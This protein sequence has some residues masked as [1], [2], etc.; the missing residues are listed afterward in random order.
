M[1][2]V[3][4]V[5]G[6]LLCGLTTL[7]PGWGVGLACWLSILLPGA[8]LYALLSSLVVSSIMEAR[9]TNQDMFGAMFNNKL[10]V[11]SE[12]LTNS[13]LVWKVIVFIVGLI[14]GSLLPPVLGGSVFVTNLVLVMVMLAS[15]GL[16][17]TIWRGIIWL[18]IV[19][20]LMLLL[21]AMGVA[22]PILVIGLLLFIIPNGLVACTS[23]NTISI[24]ASEFGV[25]P[26]TLLV[27]LLGSIGTIGI[28]PA[29]VIRAVGKNDSL[30]SNY[31][32]VLVSTVG[33][34]AIALGQA[35]QGGDLLGKAMVSLYVNSVTISYS[36]V[37]A[38]LA[39]VFISTAIAYLINQRYKGVYA[40]YVSAYV[41]CCGVILLTGLWAIVLIPLGLAISYLYK[42]LKLPVEAQG[43]TY[44]ALV[45]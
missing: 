43:L 39:V 23:K 14:V 12:L 19:Q 33:I 15:V 5:L 32:G 11:N 42:S 6:G 2:I 25:N 30:I 28:S 22:Y 10:I 27:G 9:S 4:G 8:S 3:I 44:V 41:G 34:E 26:I 29:T 20:I 37:L 13:L 18:A 7:I 17:S 24:T 40:P 45:L 16:T 35:L 21:D 38:G 1:E 31:M 36:T